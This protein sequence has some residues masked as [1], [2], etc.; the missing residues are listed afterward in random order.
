MSAAGVFRC[1]LSSVLEETPDSS[2]GKHMK[3]L[4]KE[5]LDKSLS[6]E[7]SMTLFDS[8]ST[9][10]VTKIKDIITKAS[11]NS[12]S[13]VN[14]RDKMWREFHQQRQTGLL[15]VWKKFEKFKD[16]LLEQTVNQKVLKMML[17]EHIASTSECMFTEVSVNLSSDELNVLRYVCGYVVRKLLKKYEKKS[18]NIA[19][20]CLGDLAVADDVDM[21]MI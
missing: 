9:E 12:P 5:I 16:T 18:D 15:E 3:Q 8:V 10:L 7:G 14:M 20:Q 1:V 4:A 19:S 21:V 6:D 17:S 2:R 11:A 13:K